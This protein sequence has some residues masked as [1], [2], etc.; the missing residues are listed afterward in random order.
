MNFN[1]LSFNKMIEII[2]EGFTNITVTTQSKIK[3]I[4]DIQFLYR[5]NELNGVG[6]VCKSQFPSLRRHITSITHL[7]SVG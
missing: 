4:I 6:K 2:R 5:L 7:D 3:R 1:N